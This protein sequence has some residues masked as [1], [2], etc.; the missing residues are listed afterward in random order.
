MAKIKIKIRRAQ[1]RAQNAT[2]KEDEARV[3]ARARRDG[4]PTTRT[5]DTARQF[6]AA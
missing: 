6:S 3:F 1:S 4:N 2:R 5:A